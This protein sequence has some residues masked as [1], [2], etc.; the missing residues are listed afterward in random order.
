MRGPYI[1]YNDRY[2]NLI[3]EIKA[4]TQS[5]DKMHHSSSIMDQTLMSECGIQNTGDRV[6]LSQAIR[7]MYTNDIWTAVITNDHA[8]LLSNKAA[9]EKRSLLLVCDPLYVFE[10]MKEKFR[11]GFSPIE[12]AKQGS[13]DYNS[14]IRIPSTMPRVV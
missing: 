10:E 11:G 1:E 12:A 14:L 6:I 7:F 8:D 13:V 9:I 3:T 2:G 4:I 5:E